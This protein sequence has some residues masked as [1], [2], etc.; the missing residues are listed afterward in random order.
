[1]GIYCFAYRA[2]GSQ[3][4]GNLDMQTSYSGVRKYRR[5][6]HYKALKAGDYSVSRAVA[7]WRIVDGARNDAVIETIHKA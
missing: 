1:M 5:T 6:A 4:L 7:F 2:D 3:I